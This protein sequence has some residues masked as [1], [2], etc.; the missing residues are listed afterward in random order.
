MLNK[1][2]KFMNHGNELIEKIQSKIGVQFIPAYRQSGVTF[3]GPKGRILKMVDN[4][5]W[6]YF[7]FNVAVPSI[8]GLRTYTDKEAKDKHLGTCRWIYKGRSLDDVNRLVEYA[9]EN[10]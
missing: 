5:S 2:Y 7:E 1:N 3:F 9:L 10:Y 4:G 8:D 6:L